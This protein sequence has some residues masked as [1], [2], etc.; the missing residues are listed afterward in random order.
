MEADRNKIT[1]NLPDDLLAALEG[2]SAYSGDT[3]EQVLLAWIELGRKGKAPA[4]ASAKAPTK[5]KPEADKHME[6]LNAPPKENEEDDFSLEAITMK[7]SQLAHNSVASWFSARVSDPK[8]S[9]NAMRALANDFKNAIGG[10]SELV[11][12]LTVMESDLDEAN[13]KAIC[14]DI[15][16][17]MQMAD[18]DMQRLRQDKVSYSEA[19]KIIGAITKCLHA[20]ELHVNHVLPPGSSEL[21]AM[22]SDDPKLK[23]LADVVKEA[24]EF[25]GDKNKDQL[26]QQVQNATDMP[27]AINALSKV[28]LELFKEHHPTHPDIIIETCERLEWL[29]Q[30]HPDTKDQKPIG[31]R[32]QHYMDEIK[33]MAREWDKDIQTL[34]E[35]GE[36]LNLAPEI[37]LEALGGGDHIY[38]H[39]HEVP[40]EDL[41][42]FKAYQAT[43]KRSIENLEEKIGEAQRRLQRG[44]SR[45]Q[46]LIT[47]IQEGSVSKGMPLDEVAEKLDDLS[48]NKSSMK[49]SHLSLLFSDMGYMPAHVK[50][51]LFWDLSGTSNEIEVAQRT[52]PEGGIKVHEQRTIAAQEL[53]GGFLL[54]WEKGQG[55]PDMQNIW[56][57]L[58]KHYLEHL[59][60]YDQLKAFM[61]FFHGGSLNNAELGYLKKRHSNDEIKPLTEYAK[62]AE[63]RLE[64]DITQLADRKRKGRVARMGPQGQAA[65]WDSEH[66]DYAVNFI[67]SEIDNWLDYADF[68]ASK[69]S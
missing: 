34:Q 22:F 33:S 31:V 4:K 43:V 64:I 15:G 28:S 12:R 10:F 9:P 18:Q 49:E 7:A 41:E 24:K 3:Q 29:L 50:E 23:A 45:T 60:A 47:A 32:F 27:K 65:Y 17:A 14:Q 42:A 16:R 19:E 69:M 57:K 59:L 5:S 44:L 63:L 1:L 26:I 51:H 20:A 21:K 53:S 58:P 36:Q 30:D 8:A 68:K 40:E 35:K 37:V 25:I 2:A 55:L 39:D 11:G 48:I 52:G 67:W 56:Q 6:V 62:M 66:E 38:D 46:A 13:F 54:R 61:Q